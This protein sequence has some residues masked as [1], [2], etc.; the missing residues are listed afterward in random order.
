MHSFADVSPG[1]SGGAVIEDNKLIGVISRG[2]ATWFQEE[3][4]P[5]FTWPTVTIGI[6]PIKEL[7]KEIK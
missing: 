7:L 6:G 3:G 5:K 4:K 2:C 1:A